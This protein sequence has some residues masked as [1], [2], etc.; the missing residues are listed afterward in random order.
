MVRDRSCPISGSLIDQRVSI[1]LGITLLE[2][3]WRELGVRGYGVRWLCIGLDALT[4]VIRNG[5]A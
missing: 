3:Q 1:C 5:F 2:D 4:L